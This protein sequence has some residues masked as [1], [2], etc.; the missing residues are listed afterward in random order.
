MIFYNLFGL[1]SFVYALTCKLIFTYLI[2]TLC[3]GLLFVCNL[4]AMIATVTWQSWFARQQMSVA[5]TLEPCA[6]PTLDP[7]LIP[8]FR[9]PWTARGPCLGSS[10]ESDSRSLA[11]VGSHCVKSLFTLTS[12]A[13][14]RRHQDLLR[15]KV[16]TSTKIMFNWNMFR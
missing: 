14:G 8:H 12:C 11:A 9:W 6:P 3:F 1:G 2:C 7:L 10:C 13:Q 15:I 5:K 16:S 4:K